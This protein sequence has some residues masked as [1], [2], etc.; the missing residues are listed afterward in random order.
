MEQKNT[1]NM[2]KKNQVINSYLR[3]QRFRKVLAFV[4]VVVLFVGFMSYALY[5]EYG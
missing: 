1:L 5:M 4:S 2:S 3:R